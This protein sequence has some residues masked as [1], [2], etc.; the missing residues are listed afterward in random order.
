MCPEPVNANIT[1]LRVRH[2]RA[3]ITEWGIAGLG[4]GVAAEGFSLATL[5]KGAGI[6]SI[7]WGGPV[8]PAVG[9]VWLAAAG[10]S[11][12][13]GGRRVAASGVFHR[14]A[15]GRPDQEFEEHP[16]YDCQSTCRGTS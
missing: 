8:A 3:C 1:L 4:G 13:A 14:P 15:V 2:R 11:A 16:G 6:I 7:I 10:C 5:G 9:A 12:L